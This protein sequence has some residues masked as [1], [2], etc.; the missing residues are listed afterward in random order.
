MRQQKIS[1]IRYNKTYRVGNNVIKKCRQTQGD[2]GVDR[3]GDAAYDN[4]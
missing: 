3:K 4:I 2:T 1:E